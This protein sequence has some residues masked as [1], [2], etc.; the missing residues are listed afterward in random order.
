MSGRI[1]IA[2]SGAHDVDASTVS[3]RVEVTHPSDVTVEHLT[4]RSAT[5]E[6]PGRTPAASDT[7]CVVVARSVTGRVTVR[8]R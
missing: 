2:L 1:E 5:G 4:E 6:V 8:P 3:G 7:S